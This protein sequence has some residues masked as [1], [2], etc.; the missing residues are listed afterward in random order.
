[1]KPGDRLLQRFLERLPDEL[2]APPDL[3][4]ATGDLIEIDEGIDP[5]V[6]ALGRLEAKLGRFYVLGSHDYFQSRF[7]AYTKYFTGRRPVNTHPA[8]TARLEHGLQDKGWQPLVNDTATVNVEGRTLRLVG[9]DDPYIKRHKTDHIAREPGDAA[10]IGLMHAPD[11]VSEYA[12]AGF[13]VAVAGHTHAGQVK[14][15]GVG[16]VVTNCSLPAALADGLHRIGGMW[17]HVSPG[18]GTGRFSPVRFNSPPEATLLLLE[19]VA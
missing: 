13:D 9:V 17:L 14:V 8:D 15:P 6:E 4:L 2:G 11:L 7:H 3:V 12:L 16:A 10:A 1:M 5:L 19:P 18:L